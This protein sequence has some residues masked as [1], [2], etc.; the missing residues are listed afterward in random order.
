MNKRK[1]ALFVEG[2]GELIFLREFLFRWYQFDT[3]RVGVTCYS[4]QAQRFNP[5]PYPIGDEQSENF[6]QIV[7][8]GND[9]TVLSKMLDESDR[10]TAQGYHKIVGLRDMFSDKYHQVCKN[11]VIDEDINQNFINGALKT[12]RNRKGE[13]SN[14]FLHFAIM[15]FETWL[16]AMPACW[17]QMD[18][19][20]TYDFIQKHLGID[21]SQ[22]L[23]KTIY[24]PSVVLKNICRL[25]NR[26]YDKHDK[27][28]ETIM[29]SLSKADFEALINAGKCNSFSSFVQTI[30]Y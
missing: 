18:S 9:Q 30:I 4:L 5:V 24:H 22:D 11:R 19:K 6:F 20:L 15:E 21:L 13:D 10:L 2:Q 25:I 12:I 3:N 23:E 27:E 8:V 29:A 14:C 1:I 26:D 7:N 17:Q 16:L 28:L